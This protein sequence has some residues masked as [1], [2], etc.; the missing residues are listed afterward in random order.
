M[1]CDY[2]Q[3]FPEG[4][5]YHVRSSNGERLIHWRV[6]V[7]AALVMRAER[8][9]TSK[10]CARKDSEFSAKNEVRQAEGV[11]ASRP[12]S[13]LSDASTAPEKPLRR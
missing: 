6:F 7:T 5:P 10:P 1:C 3:Y 13:A 11:S 2:I 12:V 9:D 8:F 4:Y